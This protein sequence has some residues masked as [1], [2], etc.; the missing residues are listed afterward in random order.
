MIVKSFQFWFYFILL[1]AWA[2]M[3]QEIYANIFYKKQIILILTNPK[4][5]F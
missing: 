3:G 1:F 4:K 2:K 5:I